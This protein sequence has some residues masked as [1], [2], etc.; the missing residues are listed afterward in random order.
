MQHQQFSHLCETLAEQNSCDA[1]SIV[2]TL[3]DKLINQ[4]ATPDSIGY[5]IGKF[6]CTDFE[7][8]LQ[9]L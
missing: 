6:I 4:T 7:Y 2:L 8:N 1:G 9:C 3:N 5:T